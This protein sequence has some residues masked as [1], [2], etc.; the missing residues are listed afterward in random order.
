MHFQVPRKVDCIEFE[1]CKLG[2]ENK[3]WTV[4]MTS[5]VIRELV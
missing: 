2:F 5:N 4:T 1:E 3:R